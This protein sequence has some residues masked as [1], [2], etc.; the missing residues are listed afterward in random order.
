MPLRKESLRGLVALAIVVG[1]G[2]AAVVALAFK[3]RG[4]RR[5]APP[6]PAVAERLAAG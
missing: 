6:P 4:A 2:A 5:A 1:L 3:T